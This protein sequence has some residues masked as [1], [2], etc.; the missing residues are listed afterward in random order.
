MTIAGFLVLSALFAAI[1][2]FMYKGI[3]VA[4]ERDEEEDRKRYAI[5]AYALAKKMYIE[6]LRKT[7]VLFNVKVNVTEDEL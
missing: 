1:A 2:C 6:R 4:L 7:R 3:E 5:Y